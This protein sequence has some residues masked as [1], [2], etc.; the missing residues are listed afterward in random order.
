MLDKGPWSLKGQSSSNLTKGI[1]LGVGP[2]SDLDLLLP[3]ET[4]PDIKLVDSIAASD[5]QVEVES[6]EASRFSWRDIGLESSRDWEA[7]EHSLNFLLL[8]A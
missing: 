3:T 5:G 1:F 2:P 7:D 6:K 4:C 8:H